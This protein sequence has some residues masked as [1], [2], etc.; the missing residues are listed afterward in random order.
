LKK[1]RPPRSQRQLFNREGETPG[2]TPANIAID[3]KQ[4]KN[5]TVTR[6][7]NW[8]EENRDRKGQ[9]KKVRVGISIGAINAAAG[10]EILRKW[11]VGS[12][13]LGVYEV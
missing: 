12:L 7:S 6:K 3:K 11:G 8:K 2:R 5:Q 10:R 9:I 1:H 13:A 4:K